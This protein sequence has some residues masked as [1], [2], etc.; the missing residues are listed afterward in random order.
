MA[1]AFVVFLVGVDAVDRELMKLAAAGQLHDRDVLAQQI[2]AIWC[3]SQST[4][5]GI[6]SPTRSRSASFRSS[7]V[8]QWLG[9]RA[10]G[11]EFRPDEN[12]LRGR[13]IGTR[14]A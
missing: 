3:L 5:A 1:S 8:E 13:S 11:R 12:G 6:L 2:T 4:I 9:T 7:F 14:S 10:L